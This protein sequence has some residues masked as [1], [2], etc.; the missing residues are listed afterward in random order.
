MRLDR[1]STILGA[2]LAGSVVLSACSLNPKEDPTRYYVL[3]SL[4]E[5][6]GLAEATETPAAAVPSLS[7]GVG[8]VVLAAHLR[9]TRMATRVSSNEVDYLETERWAQSL[10]EGFAYVMS[11][12]LGLLLGS[13]RV[14]VY[15]WYSTEAPDYSVRIDVRQFI[16][17]S[18]G[19]VLVSIQWELLD[20]DGQA[21][22]TGRL[23]TTEPADDASVTASVRAQSQALARL[24]QEIA[25]AIRE[26]AS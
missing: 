1:T 5:D 10:D 8:P 9:R 14:L 4:A 21:I 19:A 23:T 20:S 16:R 24:S 18:S 22:E 6:P 3:S 2:V 25:D 7:V 15:P 17:D 12:N 11:L 13:D 26:A